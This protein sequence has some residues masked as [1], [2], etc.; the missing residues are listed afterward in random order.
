[1]AAPI[2][3]FD[4]FELDVGGYELRRAGRKIRLQRVPMDLLILLIDHRGLLVT[5]DEIA[6]GVWNGDPSVDTQSSINT[7]VRKIRQALGDDGEEPRFVETVVGKGYRFIGEV[8]QRKPVEAPQAPPA[9]MPE[10]PDASAAGPNR[11]RLLIAVAVTLG[12]VAVASVA[13]FLPAFRTRPR[14][15][16]RIS[17]FTAVPGIESS[18]DFSP[19]GS[20]VAFA[21]TGD[22]GNCSQI[23]VK[24]AGGGSPERITNS[25]ECESS[26]SWSRDGRFIAFLQTGRNGEP[27]LY[28]APSSGGDARKITGLNGP[29]EY[30]PAWTPDGKALVV[31][32]SDPPGAPPG[33]FRVALNSGEKQRVTTA[34]AGGTGDW[35]PSF[36]PDGRMLGYLHNTGS[37]V[38]SPL[39]VV[40]VNERGL[41]SGTPRQIAAGSVDFSDFT[42]SADGGSFI[43]TTAS[44]LVRVPLAGGTPMPLPFPDGRQAA[45]SPRGNLMVYV[46]PFVDTDI[47]RVPGPGVAGQPTRLISSTR[48]EFSPRYSPDGSQIA[49]I[50][51][52]TGSQEIW[53]ADA[54][55][56]NIRRITSFGGPS[57]GS[58]RWSPDGNWI[59]FD[60]TA[61]GA[62]AIYVTAASGG[63]PRRITSPDVTSV[64]PSWSHDDKWIYFGSNRSGAWQIWKTTPEGAA[65]VQVTR[66]GG[67]EAFEAP[68]GDFLYYTKAPPEPG[69]W[70]VPLD[71]AVASG[72]EEKVTAA[73]SQ[74]RWAVGSRGIYYLT[75]PGDLVF[76]EFST[77][78]CVRIQTAG[79]QIGAGA[80]NM[81]A[82]A[83]DDRSLLLSVAVR[84]ESQLLLVRNFE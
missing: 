36:S 9:A 66:D 5:R 16:L 52:R 72:A 14:E 30:R 45:V 22:T 27:A 43:G 7:A 40:P 83:P 39:V 48:Q 65:P 55:G 67:R 12:A 24:A 62:S 58:P 31:M 32:H 77:R 63:P 25:R 44:G 60:S 78:R 68:G 38:L 4:E 73:G 59:A 79:L 49:F 8:S 34:E 64:R 50:S 56:R 53:I 41:P 3:D 17:P 13:I 28:V 15:P 35:C 20:E 46:Q 11:R 23:Y 26:P 42:W 82:A 2:F 71:A 6:A 19:D 75:A 54:D 61:A 51:D 1:M 76:Q 74:G 81:I 21:W 37:L 84:S 18:P 70:R 57:V 33:L 29:I 80:P 69:I 10:A 47:F